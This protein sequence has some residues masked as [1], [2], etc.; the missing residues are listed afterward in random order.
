MVNTLHRPVANVDTAVVVASI[1]FVADDAVILEAQ[2]NNGGNFPGRDVQ[3]GNGICLL[4]RDPGFFTVDRDRDVFRLQIL[5]QG[6]A[7]PKHSQ[8]LLHKLGLLTVEAGEPDP[9][10]RR[11]SHA[12]GQVNNA[13]GA[14]RINTVVITGFALVGHQEFLAIASK[15]QHIRQGAHLYFTHLVQVG[16]VIEHYL[17]VVLLD[18]GFNGDSHETAVYRHAVRGSTFGRGIN[19]AELERHLRVLDVQHVHG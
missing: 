19:G 8:A 5:G 14:L 6:G 12:V 16:A 15:R 3:F 1:Q 10:Y 11:R 7:R 13:N 17:A 18:I 9:G 2:R 4:H